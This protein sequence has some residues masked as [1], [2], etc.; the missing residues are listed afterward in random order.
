M[1]WE[2]SPETNQY[3]ECWHLRNPDGKAVAMVT[4]QH[5]FYSAAIYPLDKYRTVGRDYKTSAIAK[6]ACV[7]QLKK[8]GVI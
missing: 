7:Q 3:S 4:R 6:S 8:T 2:H 5:I 1:K